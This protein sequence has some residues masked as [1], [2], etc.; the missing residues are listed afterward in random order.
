MRRLEHVYS[1]P[2]SIVDHFEAEVAKSVTGLKSEITPFGVQRDASA[3]STSSASTSTTRTLPL[4][5]ARAILA[6]IFNHAIHARYH[7]ARDLLLMSHLQD[8]IQ[9]ADV[10]TQI[11]YNRALVQLGL[12]AFRRG[13]INECQ[14]L[15]SEMFQTQRQKEL[16]AQAVQRYNLQLSP[17]Q[18]LIEKRRLLPFHMHLNIELLRLP[19]SPRACL[20]RSPSLLP[21][22][23]R[24]SAAA[25]PPRR[26]SVSSTLP[27]SRP[28]WVL[29]RTP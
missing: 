4:L 15:L 10:T 7:Q 26:S 5:R 20:L 6:H 29:P 3:S 16:L 14:Q 25:S 18:E 22:T 11:M 23:P 19:T 17:E 27:T 9:H 21:S 2:D 1:K 13:F 24:S 8:T 28:S 12:A